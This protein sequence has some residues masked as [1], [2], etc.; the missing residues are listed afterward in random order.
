MGHELHNRK[1][2]A[3][4][5]DHILHCIGIKYSPRFHHQSKSTLLLHRVMV[6]KECKSILSVCSSRT[7]CTT[8]FFG[9]ILIIKKKEGIY[10]HVEMAES[11]DTY[12]ICTQFTSHTFGCL[13]KIMPRSSSAF[14]NPPLLNSVGWKLPYSRK[15]LCSHICIIFDQNISYIYT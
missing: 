4:P 6:Y 11:L 1:H 12:Y 14:T 13:I 9:C 3:R 8:L 10:G 7:W 5:F 15:L 2:H